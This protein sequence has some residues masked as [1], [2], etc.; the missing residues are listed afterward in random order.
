MGLRERLESLGASLGLIQVQASSD[1][2]PGKMATRTVRLQDLMQ[3]AHKSQAVESDETALEVPVGYDTVFKSAGIEA[4]AHGW[5]VE[6]LAQFLRSD[7]CRDK[8]RAE[9]QAKVIAELKQAG[10]TPED[11]V[12]DAIARDK[13]LDVFTEYAQ[14]KLDAQ[15]ASHANRLAQ[16]DAQIRALEQEREGLRRRDQ[17]LQQEWSGWRDKKRACE[18][19]MA[20]AI[21]YLIE[22]PVVSIDP[23]RKG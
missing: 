8:P 15:V 13:A 19:D 22:K 21:S 10:G 17:A 18:E 9:I 16:L 12:R 2:K 23:K 6:R 5:T 1:A 7:A 11:I 4:P 3:E 14:G 20:W